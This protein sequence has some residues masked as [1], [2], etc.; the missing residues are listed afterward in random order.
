M[1]ARGT[2]LMMLGQA[3]FLLSAFAIN[4]GLARLLGPSDY[5]TFGLVMSVLIV[6]E[7]F[8][9]TGIP[10]LVQKF[11]GEKPE[12]MYLLKHKTLPWQLFYSC[13]VF[14]LFWLASSRIAQSFGDTALAYFL[15]IASIDIV[16]YGLFKYYQGLQNGLHRFDKHAVLGIC[17]AGSKVVAIFGL[18]LSG[19]SLA[20]ALVGNMLGSIGGLAVGV[21]VTRIPK[22]SGEL[23]PIP[24]VKFIVP[25]ILYFVG[26]YLFF[27]IDLWF[28]K[29]YQSDLEVGYYVSAGALARI[30]YV[31]S[32]ALSAAL[33][34]SLSK[35]TRLRD[36]K[37]VRAMVRESLRYMIM[38]LLLFSVVV[39]T[40]ARSLVS[41][42]FGREYVAAAPALAI[43]IVGLSLITIF[44]VL[45]TVLQS[46]GRMTLSFVLMA[47]LVVLDVAANA[48]LVPRFG[49]KGAALA[50][51]TVAAVG[52]LL[53]TVFVRVDIK[54][55]LPSLST[56]R[57]TGIALIV[58]AISFWSPGLNSLVLL[59]C[60]GLSGIYFLLLWLSGEVNSAD[61][62]KLKAVI[63]KA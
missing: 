1:I 22:A 38:F 12:N 20:G 36:E 35:A 14:V 15:R 57:M 58:F 59:K 50:T 46:R 40:T 21:W 9:I 34:P 41:T 6:I 48:V 5:G 56:L 7:L 3:S 55:L 2:I 11:G 13:L 51:T 4:F 8:V 49:I 37:Q 45:N 18:V 25:N 54:A 33:L 42:L 32:I 47:V 29:I 26:L 23:D 24:Y 52:A 63:S 27:C 16:F 60:A 53:S 10:E 30:P 44:A 19:F 17:Y 39:V 31:F 61:F 43:L 28:V 62:G